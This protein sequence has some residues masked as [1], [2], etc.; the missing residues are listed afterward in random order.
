MG[1]PMWRD[2]RARAISCAMTTEPNEDHRVRVGA[3]R[4]EKTRLR[5][6][7]SALAVFASKGL[8]A[9]VIDDV[10]AAA[11]VSRGTFYNHFNTTAELLLALAVELSDE[12]LAFIDPAV[13]AQSDPVK[14]FSMGTGLYMH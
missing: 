12:A 13:L 1:V 9:T 7:Q 2:G 10:I 4:R 11:E 14:R 5:L 3:Q 8:D 6:L